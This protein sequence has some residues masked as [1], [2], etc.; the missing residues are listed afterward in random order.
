MNPRHDQWCKKDGQHL[1]IDAFLN[2][3]FRHAHFLK[4]FK[5][6]LIFV[7][8]D[9]LFIIHDQHSAAD[10]HKPQNQTKGKE[11]AV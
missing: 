1:R 8:L 5:P 9:N 4:N 10:E 3:L 7:S 2:L 11:S 6:G